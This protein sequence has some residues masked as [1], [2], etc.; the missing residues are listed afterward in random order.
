MKVSAKIAVIELTESEVRVALVK[1]GGKSPRILEAHAVEV[2][3]MAEDEHAEAQ[4]LAVQE[5][6]EALKG[7]R[8]AT[9]LCASSAYGMARQMV[10]PFKGKRKVALAVQFELEPY[11]AFP[12]EELV[13]EHSIVSEADGETEVL[14]V[15][16][17]R[18]NLE[19]Q[20]AVLEDAG[21]TVDGVGLDALGV[22]RL[23]LAVHKAPGGPY[24]LFHVGDEGSILAII[25]G[26]NLAY[27]R[28][29][30]V[31]RLGLEEQPQA[32]A[33]EVQNVLRAFSSGSKGD[34]EI[35]G[36]SVTGS[37]LDGL[38]AFEN[39]FSVPVCFDEV[40]G[41][42]AKSDVL[43]G[44]LPEPEDAT[45]RS[46]DTWS[47]LL[48]VA[49]MAA[50]GVPFAM[51]FMREDLSASAANGRGQVRRAV[52]SGFL[53]L[54]ALVGYASYVYLD[55]RSNVTEL[56][57]TGQKVWETFAETFPNAELAEQRPRGDVGGF[58]SYQEMQKEAEREQQGAARYSMDMFTWPTILAVLNVLAES[59]PDEKVG[60]T[61]LKVTLV[62]NAD[63]VITGEVKV[64]ADFGEIFD[65][66]K[67]SDVFDVDPS[68]KR[69]TRGGKETFVINARQ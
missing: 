59:M 31:T 10:I 7:K 69:S 15:G 65:E 41:L 46:L 8:V 47:A 5:A 63:Y 44:V 26:K 39:E 48:G 33:R 23:W 58:V 38:S 3:T 11:L 9:I 62:K 16:L 42:T 68:P 20:L 53:F 37:T 27:I 4:S 45:E 1:T 30:A 57:A 49:D 35:Q 24:A 67:G 64:D 21:V 50:G 54:V 60:I 2:R 6:M 28:Y 12:I 43:E 18:D 61:N 52:F 36:L 51:D 55:H 17:R 56:E 66:L 34:S 19:K 22:T 14:C 25:D 32:A 40:V 29:I 13:V